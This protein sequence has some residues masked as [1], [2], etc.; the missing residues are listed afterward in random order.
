MAEFWSEKWAPSCVC[1]TA[2]YPR[3]IH[4]IEYNL[5]PY[6]QKELIS[7]LKGFFKRD[8]EYNGMIAR[9]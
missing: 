6:I 4:N 7:D 5:G 2:A 3:K 9:D 8:N 1:H